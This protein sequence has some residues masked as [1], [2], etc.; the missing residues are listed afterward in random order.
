MRNEISD[1]WRMSFSVSFAMRS[2]NTKSGAPAR[3]PGAFGAAISANARVSG[4]RAQRVEDRL[5]RLRDRQLAAAHGQPA[6][7]EPVDDGDRQLR[8]A[9]GL[10]HSEGAQGRD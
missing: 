1:S 10:G 4:G 6:Q 8:G 5:E 9:L 3:A 2:E 7:L